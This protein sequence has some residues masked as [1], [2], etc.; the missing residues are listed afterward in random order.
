MGS[1]GS[2]A[3][4]EASPTTSGST[5]QPSNDTSGADADSGGGA[6]MAPTSSPPPN[7]RPEQGT[8]APLIANTRRRAM[9]ATL[10]KVR[11]AMP[12]ANH[13]KKDLVQWFLPSDKH[14]KE[15]L[16]EAAH[17]AAEAAEEARRACLANWKALR[18]ALHVAI[19]VGCDP[20]TPWE[21]LRATMLPTLRT[22]CLAYLS[23]VLCDLEPDAY[24][25]VL[26]YT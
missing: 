3:G 17:V 9:S 7:P 1:S 2:K 13:N 23:F 26:S 12:S 22:V 15:G 10:D 4:A 14:R 16:I 18:S 6:S 5:P 8:P 25:T 20:A 24:D 19:Q 11:E 21:R